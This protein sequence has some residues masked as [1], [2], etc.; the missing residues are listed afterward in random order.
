MSKPIE[1]HPEK[2]TEKHGG[3][4]FG[5]HRVYAPKGVLPQ[6]AE[7]LNV[8]LPIFDNE[9]LIDVESL[10][11]DSASFHQIKEV[12]E[13]DPHRISHHIMGLVETRGKHH[14]PVTG[15]GGMLIG[16]VKQIGSNFLKN[17]HASEVVKVG[18]RIA[19][20]VSLTLTP[21]HLN[22]VKKVFLDLDRVD[23]EGYAV[24][25]ESGIYSKLPN[26][27]SDTIALAVLDVCGAPAQAAAL[28]K[29]GHTVVV[30]GGAGKSGTLCMY[31]AKKSVGPSGKVIA[32]DYS[33]SAVESIK[34][35]SFVDEAG[36]CDARNAILV[37]DVVSKLTNGKMA[38]VVINV[39]NIPDTEMSCILSAKKGGVCY[40]FSMATSF[41]KATLGAEGVGAHVDLMM[42]NG[43]CPG[44]AELALNILRESKEIR[45]LYEK[46]YGTS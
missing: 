45:N 17:K 32:L 39:T 13:S 46:K 23:V 15:S 11:I 38:D 8:D 34:S 30:V 19:T 14:N 24:L 26:D 12:C 1:K 42:G 41:T 22:K 31:E 37:H 25:F 36:A 33:L 6:Q 4:R 7:E 43:Y 27:I 18:D 3:D 35:L 5:A 20:L 28:C 10:N 9:L 21:L 29:P 16:T 44:H 2:Y 40:F